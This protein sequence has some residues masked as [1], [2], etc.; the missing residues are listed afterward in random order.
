MIELH[1]IKIINTTLLIYLCNEMIHMHGYDCYDYGARHS[2]AALGRFTSPDPMAEKYCG[3][4]PYAMCNGNP[5]RYVDPDGRWPWEN[6][7]I[8]KARNDASNIGGSVNLVQG[9]YGIDAQILNN[10]GEVVNTRYATA[11]NQ[12]T[13]LRNFVETID[14]GGYAHAGGTTN[15]TQQDVAVATGVIGGIT[16]GMALAGGTSVTGAIVTAS[17]IANS[18]DDIGTNVHGESFVQQCVN[19]QPGKIAVGI[20]KTIVSGLGIRND[21]N[22]LRDVGSSIIQKTISAADLFNSFV[23]NLNALFNE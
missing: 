6:E 21:I 18:A 12:K 15:I 23:N 10:R 3:T 22:T 20:T 8:Q 17:G 16:G 14:K 11:G 13:P 5:V 2:Q 4:S 7:N 1:D 9:E 19:T